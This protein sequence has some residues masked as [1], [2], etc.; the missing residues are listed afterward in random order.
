MTCSR[1]VMYTRWWVAQ[2]YTKF[3][4]QTAGMPSWN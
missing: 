3:D 2:H 1:G 4:K